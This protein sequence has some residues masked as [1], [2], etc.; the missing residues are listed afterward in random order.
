MSILEQKM[1]QCGDGMT[2][3][4]ILKVGSAPLSFPKCI[5]FGS[6]KALQQ[7]LVPLNWSIPVPSLDEVER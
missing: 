3:L 5:G 6:L 2:A 1:Q 7:H 4:Q